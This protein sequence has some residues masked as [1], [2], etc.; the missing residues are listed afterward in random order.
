MAFSM[1]CLFLNP[2]FLDSICVLLSKW[3][4][5]YL[6]LFVLSKASQMKETADIACSAVLL[7]RLRHRAYA[8]LGFILDPVS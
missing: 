7:L 8:L 6:R 1:H 4:P 2:C 5:R 3:F